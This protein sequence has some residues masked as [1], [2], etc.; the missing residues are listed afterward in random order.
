MGRLTEELIYSATSVL[1]TTAFPGTTS[2]G[3]SLKLRLQV[4]S[5]RQALSPASLN[6]GHDWR[7][8]DK[9]MTRQTAKKAHAKIA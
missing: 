2:P 1:T 4:I 7:R 6:P 3:R 9:E 5:W 8:S